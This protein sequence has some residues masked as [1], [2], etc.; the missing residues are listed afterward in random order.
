MSKRPKV[1]FQSRLWYRE[2][3]DFETSVQLAAC[4]RGSLEPDSEMID[5]HAL[6]I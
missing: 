3:I 1:V 6:G 5:T 4:Y 2:E